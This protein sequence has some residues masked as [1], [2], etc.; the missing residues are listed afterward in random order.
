MQLFTKIQCCA[1]MIFQLSCAFRHGKAFQVLRGTP[2]YLLRSPDSRETP[3]PDVLRDY[4]GFEPAHS[5]IDL[6]P[7]MELRIENAY[8][9]KAHFAGD[10]RDFWEPRLRATKQSLTGCSS[11]PFSPCS[12]VPRLMCPSRT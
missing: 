7:L 9:E 10:C 8:Y 1:V 4:N 11:F 2:A 12:T 5:W 6:R 3:L